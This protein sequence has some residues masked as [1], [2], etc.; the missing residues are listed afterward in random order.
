MPRENRALLDDLRPPDRVA[1][2]TLM[3]HGAFPGGTPLFLAS[4]DDLWHPYR[5]ALGTLMVHGK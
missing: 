2:G 4:L 1:L 5:V 3:V